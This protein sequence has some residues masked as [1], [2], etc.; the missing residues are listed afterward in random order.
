MHQYKI[1]I[2]FSRPFQQKKKNNSRENITCMKYGND[3]ECN[4]L[5]KLEF[6]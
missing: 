2:I 3:L 1:M 4:L 6:C 5:A